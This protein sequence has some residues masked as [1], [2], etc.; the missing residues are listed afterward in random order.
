[1]NITVSEN[2]KLK[3][4]FQKSNDDVS[5]RLVSDYKNSQTIVAD[6]NGNFS[7]DADVFKNND[8]KTLVGFNT[9]KD[10]TGE[11]YLLGKTY[12]TKDDMT[13]F[14]MWC[15]NGYS[16]V[17]GHTAPNYNVEL[18]GRDDYYLG[19]CNSGSN[20][21]YIINSIIPSYGQNLIIKDTEGN[22]ITKEIIETKAI[23][24]EEVDDSEDG[25]SNIED[26]EVVEETN[27]QQKPT[28]NEQEQT[29][30]NAKE[31]QQPQDAPEEQQTQVDD[32]QNEQQEPQ[33]D[34][35][36]IA[37][38]QE[39]TSENSNDQQPNVENVNSVIK[40]LNYLVY[41]DVNYNWLPDIRAKKS[42]VEQLANLYSMLSNE[43][44][45]MLSQDQKDKITNYINA[46][47]KI[48]GE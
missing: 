30:N 35:E 29:Q 5:I 40:K 12:K 45:E 47:G 43:E 15:D 48:N 46:L 4:I 19:Y 23:T 7:L 3:P 32:T 41:T 10:G 25:F 33:N 16:F 9:K 22:V 2:T 6:G 44:Q 38:E 26:Y 1:I 24:S 13:L 36:D 42:H 8:N 37:D 14:A 17:T 11:S 18:Y 20:G 27:Q 28:I 31:E 34:T 39:N 21:D